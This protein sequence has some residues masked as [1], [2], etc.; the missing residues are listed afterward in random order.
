MHWVRTLLCLAF[1]LGFYLSRFIS[2]VSSTLY[3]LS[4]SS[5]YH[6]MRLRTVHEKNTH[7]N[8]VTLKIT[9]WIP[10]QNFPKGW[11]MLCITVTSLSI[12]EFN[13]PKAVTLK[14][15]YFLRSSIKFFPEKRQLK[16][17]TK[18][19]WNI[20]GRKEVWKSAGSDRCSQR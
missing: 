8:T 11:K 3:D 20:D 6:N 17:K 5:I 15:I 1:F 10:D 12:L 16:K 9:I 13:C 7:H 19:N 18:K 4:R 14:K 2:G